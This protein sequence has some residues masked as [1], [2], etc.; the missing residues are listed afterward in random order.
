MIYRVT[1]LT[2]E[3]S[4][5]GVR[6]EG[7]EKGDGLAIDIPTHPNILF[8]R[9][10]VKKTPWLKSAS[11]LYRPSDRR[12]LAKLVPTFV[13]EEVSLSQIGGSPTGIISAF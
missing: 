9:V 5:S 13:D 4:G 10:C 2:L 6:D 12:L 1:V 11:E 7:T 8:T 3:G